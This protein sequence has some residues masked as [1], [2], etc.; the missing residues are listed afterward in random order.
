MSFL[1]D[2]LYNVF[3]CTRNYHVDPPGEE[4]PENP[5]LAITGEGRKA[6][7]FMRFRDNCEK[8][9]PTILLLCSKLEL[10]LNISTHCSIT[11]QVSKP[12]PT[13]LN[14]IMF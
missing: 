9:T 2:S 6:T 11:I 8:I 10:S 5:E 13:K 12:R 3:A 7:R 4:N 1:W 14:E